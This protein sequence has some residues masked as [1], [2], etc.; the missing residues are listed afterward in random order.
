MTPHPFGLPQDPASNRQRGANV[1]RVGDIFQRIKG[2][3]DTP[4][5]DHDDAPA[6]IDRGRLLISPIGEVDFKGDRAWLCW[7]QL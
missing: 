6:S 2:M 7:C 4:D 1:V 3:T 5:R